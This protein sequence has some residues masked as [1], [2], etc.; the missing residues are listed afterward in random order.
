MP[1]DLLE[2][3]RYP[4]VI[5]ELRAKILGGNIARRMGTTAEEM[6]NATPDLPAAGPTRCSPALPTGVTA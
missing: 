4:E 2:G 6:G 3:Y 1:R 5:N